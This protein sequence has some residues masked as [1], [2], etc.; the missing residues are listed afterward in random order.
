MRGKDLQ[1]G[2]RTDPFFKLVASVFNSLAS[3][4]PAISLEHAAKDAKIKAQARAL[5][6]YF[7]IVM[8]SF[9]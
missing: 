9:N 6:M 1:L 8:F 4:L 3:L 7:V 2:F 5:K